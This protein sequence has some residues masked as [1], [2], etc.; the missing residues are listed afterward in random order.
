MNV[1]TIEA[2]VKQYG[3]YITL[4]DQLM[5]TA[6]DNNLMEVISLLSARQPARWTPSPARYWRAA[7]YQYARRKVGP[8]VLELSY[9]SEEDNDNLTVRAGCAA[10]PDPEGARTQ[11][12]SAQAMSALSILM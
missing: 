12:R 10:V 2:T 11:R 5:L 7:M 3:G 8:F 4:S 6:I 9:T 1:S